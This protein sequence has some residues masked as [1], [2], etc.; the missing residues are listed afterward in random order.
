MEYNSLRMDLGHKQLA[1]ALDMKNQGLLLLH[2]SY[3]HGF[4][5]FRPLSRGTPLFLSLSPS[6]V[7]PP[8]LSACITTNSNSKISQ[9]EVS[10]KLPHQQLQHSNSTVSLIS[11]DFQ[12]CMMQTYFHMHNGNYT[13][14]LKHRL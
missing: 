5:V 8:S 3:Y 14:T 9:T 12:S 4:I 6:L 10:I 1:T 11:E 2:Q 13:I 7:P